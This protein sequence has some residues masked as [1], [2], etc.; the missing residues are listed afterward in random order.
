[1]DGFEGSY[2]DLDGYTVGFE[3]YT[4][5]TDPDELAQLFTG[6]PNDRCQCP[7]WGVVLKGKL[8]YRYGDG[9]EDVITT[10]QAYYA[11]P[12]HLPVFFEG[13]EIVEFS[14]SADFAKTIE[15]V[16]ANLEAAGAR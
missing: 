2:E 13:T 11:R 7:H 1:M 3:T 10:G 16:L 4:A 9:G 15:V 12:D 8:V 6:L 14:P 5:D